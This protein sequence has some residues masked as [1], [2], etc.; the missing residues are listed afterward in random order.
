[1]KALFLC[2]GAVCWLS[3]S[4]HPLKL[5]VSATPAIKAANGEKSAMRKHPAALR[6]DRAARGTPPQSAGER[7]QKQALGAHENDVSVTRV[8][9]NSH[10][11]LQEKTARYIH[12]SPGL[13]VRD[14]ANGGWKEAR[15]IVR[16]TS[17][18]AVAEGGWF[19]AQFARLSTADVAFIFGNDETGER[20]CGRVLGLQYQ[21]AAS[22][23]TVLLAETRE[24]AVQVTENGRVTYPDAFVG[25]AGD[26]VYHVESG[27]LEQDIVNTAALPDPATWG[28]NPA[29]TVI[30]AV[31]R[32]HDAPEP[33]I[34]RKRV[35]ME[36]EPAGQVD[37]ELDDDDLWFGSM[38]M[39]QGRMFPLG[40][41]G[42]SKGSPDSE[43]ILVLKR[44]VTDGKH[45]MLEE[46]VPYLAYQKI[47]REAGLKDTDHAGRAVRRGVVLDFILVPSSS[48]T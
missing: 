15:V 30:Q 26:I 18:G 42:F 16:A 28:L 31:T 9:T 13:N 20:L 45:A 43:S 4:A 37:A 36:P 21:D 2:F 35:A 8:W 25:A 40:A 48:T 11:Q 19:T 17:E 6:F 1:M 38:H 29:T 27:R 46:S 10:G 23:R 22:G 5:A 34:Y 32:F 39:T 3:A 14:R 12:L 41:D 33:Q 47:E 24:V 7:L 44:W